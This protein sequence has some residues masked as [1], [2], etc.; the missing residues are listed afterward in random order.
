MVLDLQ[1]QPIRPFHELGGNQVLVRLDGAAAD[2]FV[3][4]FAIQPHARRI[5]AADSQDNWL[6]CVSLN[7]RIGIS[8]VIFVLAKRLAQIDQ[9]AVGIDRFPLIGLPA[10]I[11]ARV[12]HRCDLRF[13]TAIGQIVRGQRFTR[14]G[15]IT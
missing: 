8:D 4:Q 1:Q 14:L 5:I 2:G 3:N 10:D 12:G 9:V 7:L 15:S 13:A 11:Y 6:R